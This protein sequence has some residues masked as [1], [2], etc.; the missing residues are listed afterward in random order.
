MTNISKPENFA[1]KYLKLD[2]ETKI[3]YTPWSI[4][5]V[6][7]EVRASASTHAKKAGMTIGEWLELAIREK[8]KN[9]RN[10]AKS[11]VTMEAGK[12][13]I[14]M[15]SVNHFIDIITKMKNAGISIPER[16]SS[17]TDAMVRHRCSAFP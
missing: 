5:G 4:R 3:S 8:I 17:Q 12:P 14:D 11:I 15:N 2:M 1:D 9:D 7:P 10:S 13:P 6:S 16:L